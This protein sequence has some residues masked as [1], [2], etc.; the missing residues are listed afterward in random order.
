M[1]QVSAEPSLQRLALLMSQ[2]E[3]S[4]SCVDNN[5]FVEIPCPGS[6]NIGLAVAADQTYPE[7]SQA[8]WIVR[9]D[10]LDRR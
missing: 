8:C 1:I 9:L 5:V 7:C 6:L 4:V 10:D 3:P 2:L